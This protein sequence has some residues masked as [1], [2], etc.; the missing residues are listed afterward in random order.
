MKFLRTPIFKENLRWLLLTLKVI[1]NELH[2]VNYEPEE[3]N[4]NYILKKQSPHAK[5]L[6]V[7]VT[8]YARLQNQMSTLSYL[9]A[10]IINS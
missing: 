2:M 1:S 5:V 10:F 9:S 7:I 3:T 8:P 4:N 6:R